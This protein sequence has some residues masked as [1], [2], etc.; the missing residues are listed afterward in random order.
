MPLVWGWGSQRMGDDYLMDTVS[1]WGECSGFIGAS[2]TTL[3][4]T[5]LNGY[6]GEWYVRQI[7]YLIENSI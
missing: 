3:N 7:L 5:F 1:F 2:C 4:G 6:K